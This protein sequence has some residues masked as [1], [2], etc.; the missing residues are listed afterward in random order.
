MHKIQICSIITNHSGSSLLHSVHV[1]WKSHI[2]WWSD[3]DETAK[4]HLY[5]HCALFAVVRQH[6]R[7]FGRDEPESVNNH[8]C[9]R[10]LNIQLLAQFSLASFA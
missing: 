3:L 8:D 2:M 1:V 10:L 7:M 6:P 5:D 9:P 4:Q